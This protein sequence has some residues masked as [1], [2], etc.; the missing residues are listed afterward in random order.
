MVIPAYNAEKYI[1]ETLQS[2]FDQTYRNYEVIVVDDGSMDG[3]LQL[4]QGYAPGVKVVGKSNG[5]PASARN[6]AI[7]NSDGEL[8]AFL[9]SDDL[10]FTDK[11]DVQV[12]FLC[13]NPAVGLVYGEALM[14][15]QDDGGETRKIGFTE[16]PSFC[17]LL[18]GDFIPNSTVIVRRSCVE[19]AG[20]LNESKELIA[21]EDYEYW[22]RIAKL[23]PIAGIPRPLAY[24][25]VRND[26]LVGD[27]KDIEKGLELALAVIHQVEERYPEMWVECGVDR[28]LL[29]ARL[30][31]RAGF[32]WKKRGDWGQ[33]LLK[34]SNALGHSF[35]PRVFRWIVAA[36]ILN[37]W[38]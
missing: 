6:V 4:L 27:G 18:Y 30:H 12:R 16:S 32:A 8:I 2:V 25:R 38:S 15:G 20:L 3:T 7:N 29:L 33:C 24:Y 11:L 10:W 5:G 35:T 14:V 36:T 19:K 21:A 22:L 17:K 13:E 9:D 23:F 1:A 28:N 31:V 26:S 34:F 37:R